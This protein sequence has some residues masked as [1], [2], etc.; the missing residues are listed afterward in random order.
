M[1]GI[2]HCPDTM[3]TDGGEV[4]NLTRRCALLPRII[5]FS[6]SGRMYSVQTAYGAYPVSECLPEVVSPGSKTAVT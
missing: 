6:A 3:L 2:A 1:L 5:S 4:V